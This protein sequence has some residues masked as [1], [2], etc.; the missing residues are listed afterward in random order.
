MKFQ[1]ILFWCEFPD[2]VNWEIISSKLTKPIHTYLAVSSLQEFLD[3][4]KK[5][6]RYKN[7]ILEG[8]WPT[9]PKEKGYWFS[10]FTEKEDIDKLLEYKGVKIKVDIEPPIPPNTKIGSVIKWVFKY[11]FSKPKNR[12]YLIETIREFGSENIIVSTFPFPNWVLRRYGWSNE[13]KNYNY[14]HYSSFVPRCLRK[15]YSI[16]YGRFI[17]KHGTENTYYAAGLL[18]V[19]VFGNEPVYSSK[20]ELDSDLRFLKSQGVE[21]IVIFRAGSLEN[22]TDWLEKYL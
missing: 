7:I 22:K 14:M 21:N 16:Y 2:K 19:G 13:F 10:S 8:A 12:E 18:D 20:K 17:K 15:L 4:K 1:K 3:Y 11:I 6:A 9:L 5:L